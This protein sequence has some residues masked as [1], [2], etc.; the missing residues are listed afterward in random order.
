MAIKALIWDM[1][2]VIVDSEHHHHEGEIATFKHFGVDVPEDVNKQYKG[3]PLHEH[4]QGLKD[5]FNVQTPLEELLDKQNAHISKMYS[6]YV[7]LFS[8]VK[9]VLFEFKQKY[10]QALATS[11]ERKLVNIVLKRFDIE[12]VF[13]AVT[14]GDEVEQGK[15]APDIFLKTAEKLG[16]SPGEAVVIEDSFNGIK[17]G[18]AA[19]MVVIAHKAHHN[20]EIDFSLADFVV[21]DLR[22]I[23][24]ILTSLRAEQGGASQS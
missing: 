6:E 23:P 9:E 1:D 22:E 3:S 18:K 14:C 2:G 19:G 5:R 21:K 15:P 7:E 8:N 20:S 24:K 4:F 11:S 13:D 10:L 17:A 16:V 12:E